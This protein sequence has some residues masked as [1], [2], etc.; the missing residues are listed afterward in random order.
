MVKVAARIPVYFSHSRIDTGG[1][2]WLFGSWLVGHSEVGK[3]IGIFMILL[4][5]V[6]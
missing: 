2:G 4:E 1:K 3:S 5:T 6:S